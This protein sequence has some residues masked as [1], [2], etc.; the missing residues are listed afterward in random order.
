MD[1]CAAKQSNFFNCP[2]K[3]IGLDKLGN[4]PQSLF[5]FFLGKVYTNILDQPLKNIKPSDLSD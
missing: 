4:F 3:S 2:R 1:A 5:F